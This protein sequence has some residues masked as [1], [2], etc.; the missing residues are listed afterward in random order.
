MDPIKG[1]AVRVLA[2]KLVQSSFRLLFE[3]FDLECKHANK[4]MLFGTRNYQDFREWDPEKFVEMSFVE[5]I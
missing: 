4:K 2:Q 1:I 5:T 3:F